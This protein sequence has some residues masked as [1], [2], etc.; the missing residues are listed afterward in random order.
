MRLGINKLGTLLKR[1]PFPVVA[2]F[3]RVIAVSFAF[4]VEILQIIVI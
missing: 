2:W 3:D 1:H 4:P